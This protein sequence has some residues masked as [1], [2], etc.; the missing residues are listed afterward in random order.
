M[1]DLS[2]M[3]YTHF[4]FG[5]FTST[6]SSG[7]G[8]TVATGTALFN[9]QTRN[10]KI[11]FQSNPV[12]GIL[13]SEHPATGE[14]KL[15]NNSSGIVVAVG[16]MTEVTIGIK[17]TDET[18]NKVLDG[19][20]N[21]D[22]TDLDNF[23]DGQFEGVKFKEHSKFLK[24]IR[25]PHAGG[26]ATPS[27]GIYHKII[28]GYYTGW[29]GDNGLSTSLLIGS[30]NLQGS[31]FTELVTYKNATTTHGDG[32]EFGITPG[33]LDIA[34]QVPV[35]KKVNCGCYEEVGYLE[36]SHSGEI[37]SSHLRE[38]GDFRGQ[39]S[40]DVKNISS[41]HG[42]EVKSSCD[43]PASFGHYEESDC[44][45]NFT[46]NKTTYVAKFVNENGCYLDIPGAQDNKLPVCSRDDVKL[47]P[48]LPKGWENV[49]LN[50]NCSGTACNKIEW[51]QPMECNV[52]EKKIFIQHKHVQF[53]QKLDVNWYDNGVFRG[54]LGTITRNVLEDQVTGDRT[55]DDWDNSDI[56]F[57]KC[58]PFVGLFQQLGNDKNGAWR[59]LRFDRGWDLLYEGLNCECNELKVNVRYLTPCT[60]SDSVAFNRLKPIEKT[61]PCDKCCDTSQ[62]EIKYTAMRYETRCSSSTN[63]CS[64]Y[65]D[66]RVSRASTSYSCGCK[67]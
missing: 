24:S 61:E 64:N 7:T 28:D 42:I 43:S 57:T 19:V 55:F 66:N 31:S 18:I 11:E 22:L 3:G 14:N 15:V 8:H 33:D 38:D 39:I 62:S 48:A 17:I 53:V 41:L 1:I 44:S 49:K 51:S 26:T 40:G 21:F 52:V 54:Y 13:G 16:N 27:D 25:N 50:N 32:R 65:S 46:L 47:D 9:N 29:D 4:N 34:I 60:N 63:T 35:H 12:N 67:K 58:T 23:N 20:I 59:D 37:L 2:N 5:T 36:V 6:V 56:K 10:I 45:V 30:A